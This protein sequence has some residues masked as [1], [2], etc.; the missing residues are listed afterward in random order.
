MVSKKFILLLF[1]LL[2]SLV[3]AINITPDQLD[4][5]YQLN[6]INTG[7]IQFHYEGNT[8]PHSFTIYNITLVDIPYLNVTPIS[9]LNVNETGNINYSYQ[10]SSPVS[11]SFNGRIIYNYLTNITKDPV[12]YTATVNA[13][14]FNPVNRTV[15]VNDSV[16]WEN[17]DTSN[18]TITNLN[19][20]S[21]RYVLTPGDKLVMTFSNTGNFSYYD[22]YTSIGGF[23]YIE[24]NLMEIFTHTP[25]YDIPITANFQYISESIEADIVPDSFTMDYNEQDEGVLRLKTN[26]TVFNIHLSGDWFSFSDNNFD[27][28]GTK[29]ITFTIKPKD[30]DE[31]SETGKNYDKTILIT[32]Q[33]LLN[34]EVTVPIFIN[35]FNFTEDESGPTF[36]FE[37]LSAEETIKY[38]TDKYGKDKKDWEGFC[39]DLIQ[40]E[41]YPVYV[42]QRFYPELNESDFKKA[43]DAPDIIIEATDRLRTDMENQNKDQNDKI[44]SLENKINSF[45]EKLTGMEKQ[46][47]TVEDYVLNIKQNTSITSI[48]FWLLV[49]IALFI[50]LIWKLI[51]WIKTRKKVSTA[52]GI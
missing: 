15:F 41:S 9:S 12:N 37:T 52:M 13:T 38:C 32:G 46:L 45:E 27:L 24:S 49:F 43:V 20:P 51:I 1:L 18:H 31:T 26:N 7:Q 5:T 6:E 19:N 10:I 11:G 39:Q 16:I 47:G 48:I 33:N 21:Q 14:G 25:S 40:N 30:I 2:F 36:I 35:F 23:V 29:L 8:T 4:L 44:S 34:K 22:E 50:V 17:I 28:D 3:S 42:E